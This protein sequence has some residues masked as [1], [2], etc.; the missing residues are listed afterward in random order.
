MVPYAYKLQ[1]SF[2]RVF[3]LMVKVVGTKDVDAGLIP[4][5]LA[6]AEK[7]RWAANCKFC[8]FAIFLKL[9]IFNP[10]FYKST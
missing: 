9:E 8:N 10:I 7:C 3:G 6:Q 5:S 1:H 2:T 4:G